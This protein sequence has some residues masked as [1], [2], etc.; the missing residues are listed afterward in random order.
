M[1]REREAHGRCTP[2]VALTAYTR[3]I[4]RTR[5]LQAASTRTSPNQW[6]RTSS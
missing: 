3:A 2:A 4:D 5:A 6:M 1:L